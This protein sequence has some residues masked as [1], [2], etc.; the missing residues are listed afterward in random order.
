MSMSGHLLSEDGFE[1]AVCQVLSRRGFVPPQADES[2][3]LLFDGSA[4][5]MQ[6]TAAEALLDEAEQRRALRFRFERDRAAYVLAHAFWRCVLGR[7]LNVLGRA[8][9][10]T[11]APSGQP[12]LA[13]TE[14]STSISRAGPWVTIAVTRAATVGVDIERSPSRS[15]LDDLLPSFCAAEEIVALAGLGALQ[16]ERHALAI[17]ARKEAVLKALGIGLALDPSSFAAPPGQPVTLSK[18]SKRTICVVRDLELDGPL[19]GALAV[20]AS[21]HRHRFIAI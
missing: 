11:R 17:W 8:V 3:T 18:G 9:P 20:P 5:A 4:W 16:R 10:L 14:W 19:V 6:V 21:V 1:R 15:A 2:C 12:Q 7:C 13:G